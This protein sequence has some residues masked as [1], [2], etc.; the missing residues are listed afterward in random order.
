M[1]TQKPS[2]HAMKFALKYYREVATVFEETV[3]DDDP[4]ATKFAA[5]IDT[6]AIRPAV[7]EAAKEHKAQ[8]AKLMKCIDPIKLE[9][10][11][12][13]LIYRPLTASATLIG[14]ARHYRAVLAKHERSAT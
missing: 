7:E 13:Q 12:G 8:I 1:S 5:D 2:E 10:V 3:P 14:M 6:H 9:A 4:I 11:A